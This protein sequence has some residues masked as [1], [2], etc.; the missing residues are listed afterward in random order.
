VDYFNKLDFNH[1][2]FAILGQ[3][4]D[5]PFPAGAFRTETDAKNINIEFSMEEAV[6][7]ESRYSVSFDLKDA[8]IS[9]QETTGSI[10]VQNTGQI[11]LSIDSS[12]LNSESLTYSD[13]DKLST[14]PPYGFQDVAFKLKPVLSFS[15]SEEEVVFDLGGKIFRQKYQIKPF[16]FVYF[17][18]V[19]GFGGVS[20]VGIGILFIHGKRKTQDIS[21]DSS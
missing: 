3:Q 12:S 17:S 20:L 8:I 11:L 13:L 16:Y 14:I 18:W 15:G 7:P 2:T 21:K 10:A 1:I 9:G 4:S 5:Y 6:I 19:L